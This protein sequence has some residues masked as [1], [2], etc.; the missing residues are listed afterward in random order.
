VLFLLISS[1]LVMKDCSKEKLN[2]ILLLRAEGMVVKVKCLLQSMWSAVKQNNKCI[3]VR[4]L[5]HSSSA[6]GA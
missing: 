1:S 4:T 5:K 6:C 3:S 2:M